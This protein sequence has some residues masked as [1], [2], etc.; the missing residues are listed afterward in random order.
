MMR[1]LG[2]I[3]ATFEHVGEAARKVCSGITL[4]V[5]HISQISAIRKAE[6]SVGER[7]GSDAQA[8]TID[9]PKAP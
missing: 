8:R 2:G 4:V 3:D 7:L 9:G 5:R 1:S 6:N